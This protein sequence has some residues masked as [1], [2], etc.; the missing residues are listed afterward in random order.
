MTLGS[1][2]KELRT[3]VG[4]GAARDARV[5]LPFMDS[6]G[7]R[8]GATGGNLVSVCAKVCVWQNLGGLFFAKGRDF[9][10][11]SVRR[12]VGP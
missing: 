11:R 6:T 9:V 2:R 1:V 8:E 5:V 7:V 4:V 3:H 10:C 12:P